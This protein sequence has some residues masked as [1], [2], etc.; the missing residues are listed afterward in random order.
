MSVIKNIIAAIA[1][2]FL[3][4]SVPVMA[5]P[6]HLPDN[7]VVRIVCGRAAG[8]AFKVGVDDYL[9]V[10]HVTDNGP[11]SINGQPVKATPVKGQDFA[12]VK[13]PASPRYLRTSCD[14]FTSGKTYLAAGF[15]SVKPKVTHA[16]WIATD[17]PDLEEGYTTFVGE[18]LPGM[19][20]GPVLDSAGVVYGTVNMRWPT[21]SLPLKDTP[22]CKD[23]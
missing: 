10:S 9:T 19:S 22:F 23:S 8:T 2:A 3:T 7:T 17:V 11:C 20:G 4:T 14:G 1:C 12:T 16:P 13:G 18:G 6:Y 21:R 15:A 5:E